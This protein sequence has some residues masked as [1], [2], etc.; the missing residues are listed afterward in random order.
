MSLVLS[1]H[2]T[3][4]TS[5]AL[6]SL[7]EANTASVLRRIRAGIAVH[8]TGGARAQ[9]ATTFG[10]LPSRAELVGGAGSYEH[11]AIPVELILGGYLNL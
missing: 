10:M 6:A 7:R 2:V 1:W 5:D 8:A 9:R 11:I 3:E 4:Q